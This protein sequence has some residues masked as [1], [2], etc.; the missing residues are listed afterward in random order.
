MHV[1]RDE[2]IVPCHAK[3]P[4]PVVEHVPVERR[5]SLPCLHR[6]TEKLAVFSLHETVGLARSYICPDE[7]P[8]PAGI[9]VQVVYAVVQRGKYRIE[10]NFSHKNISE[11]F[12]CLSPAS[13]IIRLSR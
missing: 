12:F 11:S 9:E 7:H 13:Y 10:D 3:P 1:A 5:Q 6:I 4:I 2:K 8:S